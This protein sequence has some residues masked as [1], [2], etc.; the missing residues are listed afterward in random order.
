MYRV[1]AVIC[2][3]LVVAIGVL[4]FLIDQRSASIRQLNQFAAAGNSQ[5]PRMINELTRLDSVS[6]DVS[7]VVFNY[8]I[9]LPEP[10]IDIDAIK[11]QELDWFVNVACKNVQVQSMVLAVCQH[12]CRVHL[13][14]FL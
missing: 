13:R 1:I 8:T 7:A 12:T 6:T 14:N 5:T 2:G 4:W 11:T 10:E 9:L 3:I